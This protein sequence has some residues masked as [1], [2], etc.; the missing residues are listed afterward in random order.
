MVALD[1][2]RSKEELAA[3]LEGIRQAPADTGTLELIVRRP[4][5]DE[6]EVLAEASLDLVE[7]LV[8]DDWI[9]RGSRGMS[10][11]GPNPLAQVTVMSARAVEAGAGDRERWPLAGDQLY[12]DL[13]LSIDNLPAGTRLAIGEAVLEV[14]EEPHTGCDKFTARFGSEAVKFVNKPPGR[15]L[16]LR[17]LNARVV[18]PGTV[19]LGDTVSKL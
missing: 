8:G 3:A 14:T 17:G 13:D 16:R 4:R 2:H 9:H 18:T 15:E 12:V 7:G 11:G 19:R 5:V 1:H 6:R 10:D